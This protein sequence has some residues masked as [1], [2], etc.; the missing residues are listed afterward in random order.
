MVIQKRLGRVYSVH[1]QAEHAV[2]HGQKISTFQHSVECV[3]F[4]YNRI[5]HSRP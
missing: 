4:R 3:M 1:V 5:I 2:D